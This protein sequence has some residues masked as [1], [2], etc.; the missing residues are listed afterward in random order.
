MLEGSVRKGGGT[1]RVTAQLIRA[2]N[3]HHLWSKAYDRDIHD[4]FKVQHEIVAAVVEA[5]KARLPP[6]QQVA[7]AH[8]R[9]DSEAYNQYLVGRQLLVRLN[10]ED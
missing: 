2:D 9:V 1:I 7:S 10:S 4:I 5:L 3:G 8:R 6:A